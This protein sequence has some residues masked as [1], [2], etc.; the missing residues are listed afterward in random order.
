MAFC[1]VRLNRFR[2]RGRFQYANKDWIRAF[3]IALFRSEFP[4]DVV[5]LVL[6]DSSVYRQGM[7]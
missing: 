3:S 6:L 4:V 5:L 7:R 2:A 1:T